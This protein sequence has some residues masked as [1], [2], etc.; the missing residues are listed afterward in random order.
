MSISCL[1][2]LCACYAETASS[3][4]MTDT[5][6]TTNNFSNKNMTENTSHIV[7][8]VNGNPV[9]QK[10]TNNKLAVAGFTRTISSN[11]SSVELI[12]KYKIQ[13]H[14]N[15]ELYD[16]NENPAAPVSQNSVHIG[17]HNNSFTQTHWNLYTQTPRLSVF[18]G[19][20]EQTP[21][22]TEKGSTV[23]GEQL[24]IRYS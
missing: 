23:D 16:E 4:T 10:S 13:A 19:G 22:T 18:S 24:A 6:I 1:S 15:E 9:S 5:K 14:Q 2:S 8:D 21:E 12:G 11:R 20:Q 17:T 3:E 7:L